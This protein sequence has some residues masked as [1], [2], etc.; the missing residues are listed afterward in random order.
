MS[1]ARKV[2]RL[3]VGIKD[4]L[5]LAF[6]L[7]FFTLL[8]AALSARPNPGSVNEG[9]L[10]LKLDGSI[11]EEV[12][13]IDPFSTL[14]SRSLPTREYAAHEL[15]DAIDSAAEDDRIK[16][17]A[18]DLTTFTGGGQV[19]VKDVAEALA[20]FRAT[21][22]PV[23]AYALAYTD[24]AM[25]L[26]AQANDVWV[27]P[28]GGVAIRGPGGTILFYADALERFGVNAHVYQV[29]DYKGAGE[30]Y[31]NAAMSPEF[32]Q[33]TEA[34]IGELWDEYRAAIVK[35][36]PEAD[37]D[38][39][40]TDIEAALT[41]EDGD[42]AKLALSAGFADSIGT[43]AQWGAH[44]AE[45]AG[46]DQWSDHPAAFAHT[47]LDVY[48]A[49][50][51]SEEWAGD[52]TIGVV[53][54]AGAINDSEAGPGTAG[55]ARIER[56]L[57][58]ALDDDLAALVVRIDSPGGTVTG[59]ETIR[60]ALMRYRDKKIPVVVSM[61]NYAASG[62]YWIS[63]AGERVFAEPETV[64]GS[65]G[66]VL[67]VPSFERLLQ[68]Y[69]VNPERV[70]VTPL[71]GQ[72]DVLGGFSPEVDALMRI[73][74]QSLYRRFTGLVARARKLSPAQIDQVAQGRVWTGGTARQLGL[75]DQFGGLDDAL[76]YA[77]QQAGLEEGNWGV[78]RLA[79]PRDPFE[80]MVAGLL[81]GEA[82]EA[83]QPLTVSAAIAGDNGR[84]MADMLRDLEQMVATP[85]V[86]A[87]C[88]GCVIEG[89]PR[90]EADTSAPVGWSAV[91]NL[92]SGH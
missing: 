27:D 38:A 11:V 43:Y 22:K 63:T 74:T 59:S 1:F 89:Q 79:D 88:L 5:A 92:L 71:S 69:G 83:R 62:G 29:G 84:M 75:V 21:G 25:M 77:A 55:A 24:D 58:D 2:W 78:K 37:F 41:A 91:L 14:L 76:A 26:A 82:A 73:E 57:D 6:F 80:A 8:F 19:S 66:V 7:L 44:M 70:A 49:N 33:N 9:A 28:L 50:T 15:V 72:P 48:L 47:E 30:P 52:K 68:E 17:I 4:A 81:T 64:T 34:Y 10:L 18:L 31:A 87:R 3:L 12:A 65:I 85:G 36:R 54:I 53:T 45:L 16:A 42:L 40:T 13:E 35:N 60:R 51:G 46:K 90:K 23:S 61:A 67:T 32:R 39:I 20:R 86:Q 56:L